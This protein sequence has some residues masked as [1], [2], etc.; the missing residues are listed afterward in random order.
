MPQIPRRLYH[1]ALREYGDRSHWTRAN[2]A[3]KRVRLILR[4][5][6]IEETLQQR[7]MGILPP[8]V[9][10][11][12]RILSDY[13]E[14]HKKALNNYRGLVPHLG[15]DIP[16]D[17]LELTCGHPR[18]GAPVIAALQAGDRMYDNGESTRGI[19][20]SSNC[21]RPRKVHA[22]LHYDP[23]PDAPGKKVRVR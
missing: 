2:L 18:P 14:A 22:I 7:S 4:L 13:Q 16:L 8:R 19:F 17:E 15:S 3:S 6:A 21:A 20:C 10:E 23:E 5:L 11:S 9:M 1:G 12:L